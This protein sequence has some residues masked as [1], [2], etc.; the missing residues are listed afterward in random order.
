MRTTVLLI[1]HGETV[2]NAERRL[3]GHIDSPLNDQG[4]R[5]AEALGRALAAGPLAAVVA[6]DLQRAHHT[7]L[8]V[9]APHG[10]AVATDAGLRERCY[11][12]FEGLL[13]TEIAER[14]PVDY[15]HWQAR[16]IDALMPPGER[17]G[18]SF[19]Q[20]YR[21][22]VDAIVAHAAAHPGQTIAIVAHGGVLECAYREALGMGAGGARDFAIK[23]ASINRF[24]VDGGKLTLTSWGEVDHLASAT[25]DELN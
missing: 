24:I 17:A 19:G 7:A 25:M 16:H 23:N 4:R 14:Y 9:A 18:E 13:H 10:L 11:G 20:F 15:A 12:I 3:Q 22:A 5:Q 21:R 2:S 6:S 8:A 1:R